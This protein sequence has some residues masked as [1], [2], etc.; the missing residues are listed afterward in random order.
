MFLQDNHFQGWSA[1]SGEQK[2]KGR[3]LAVFSG[4]ETYPEPHPE[5]GR[6]L[7][8]LYAVVRSVTLSQCGHWMMGSLQLAGEAVTVSGAYGSDGLPGDLDKLS[9]A[10]QRLLVEVPFDLAVEFWSGGGWNSAGK[11]APAMRKWAQ[12][13]IRQLRRTRP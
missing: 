9:E 12:E 3:F 8:I 2:A 10:Q 1:R 13:H 6:Q 4:T 5:T 7:P 11:E